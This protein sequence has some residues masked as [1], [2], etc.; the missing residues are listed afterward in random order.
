[1]KKLV[2]L[3][4]LLFFASCV[5]EERQPFDVMS[6]F[7]VG[8]FDID[9]STEAAITIEPTMPNEIIEEP[10]EVFPTFDFRPRSPISGRLIDFDDLQRR[11]VAVV[12][13]NHP[14]ARPQDGLMDADII[15]EVLAEGVTTRFVAIFHS[16][17]PEKIGPV[18]S[19]RTYF[20]D[21]ALNHDSIYVHH[22]GSPSGYTRLRELGIQNLDGIH[23]EGTVFW[24]DRTYPSWTNRSG[25]Q[26][27]FEHSSYTS[28]SRIMAN[29]ADRGIRN[30]IGE[31]VNFGFRFGSIDISTSEG[32]ATDFR[33]P[34]MSSIYRD[35]VFNP[36]TGLYYVKAA[37]EHIRDAAQGE[38][39]TVS[40]ILIQQVRI[41]ETDEGA[42]RRDA[43]TIGEGTGYMIR[44]GRYWPVRWEKTSHMS[45]MRWYFRDFGGPIII[46]PGQV[47]ICAI[48]RTI[49]LEFN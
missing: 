36:E 38:N 10:E 12:I 28:K 1:M 48:G 26:R 27:D 11:P 22:G 42:G 40:T 39:V 37:G 45:P 47:W 23:L 35:F 7:P 49:E 21:F 25:E 13:N 2:L 41:W 14:A 19:T 43:A 3:I 9:T 30:T 24:R 46:S 33:V 5:E 16:S 18:R 32:A 17:I 8:Y 44:D 34:F 31:D 29:V 15:Y 20:L 4:L 6:I